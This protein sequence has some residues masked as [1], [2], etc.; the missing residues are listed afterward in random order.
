MHIMNKICRK[1]HPVLHS[2][3]L[4][5]VFQIYLERVYF[6]GCFRSGSWKSHQNLIKW[7]IFYWTLHGSCLF[8]LYRFVDAE[9]VLLWKLS[10][11]RKFNLH[12]VYIF[13]SA[14]NSLTKFWHSDQRLSR[15][16]PSL[17]HCMLGVLACWQVC[18]FDVLACLRARVFSILARFMSLRAHIPYMLAVLKYLTCLCL[19]S[20]FDRCLTGF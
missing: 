19:V 7:L 8:K 9:N 16:S 14:W 17:L 13:E 5:I 20:S 15:N 6:L 10:S 12:V 4:L 18:V 2:C 1:Y 3:N 11:S